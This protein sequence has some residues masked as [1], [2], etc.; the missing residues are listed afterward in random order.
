MPKPKAIG[1]NAD[2]VYY[3]TGG[4]V[5]CWR[6]ASVNVWPNYST[7]DDL[8]AKLEKAGYPARPGALSIGPP[9]GPPTV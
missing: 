6:P 7:A 3:W 5:C 2:V 8:V 4:S 1:F 9:E